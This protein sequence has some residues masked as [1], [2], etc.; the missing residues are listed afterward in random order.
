MATSADAAEL[1]HTAFDKS[2]EFVDS[3]KQDSRAAYEEARHWVPNHPTAV[4]VSA[5]AAVSLG[6]IGY[7]IG[8]RG[9][10]ERRR[11]FERTPDF[12]L[13]PFFR[14]FGLWMLY[15]VATRD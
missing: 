13:S 11:F 8:R 7:A 2:K 9:R 4:A 12:G 15:R 5:S 10:P 6:L 14:L 3:I 1:L